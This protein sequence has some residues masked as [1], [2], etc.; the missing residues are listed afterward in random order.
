ML[1][2][3]CIVLALLPLGVAAEPLS[4]NRQAVEI[5]RQFVEI[6]T[7]HSTGSTTE[8]AATA[9]RLLL[10]AGFAE[11]DVQIL[12]EV[13][14]K[15]NLVARYR[16]RTREKKPVLLLA[17]IDVVAA[18]AADWSVPPFQFQEIDGYYYGRGTL[19]DKDEAAAHVANFIRWRREGFVPE[20][21]IV[22]ALTADEEGGPDNGAAYLLREHPDLVDAEFVINEGGGGALVQGRPLYVAIQASEKIYQSYVLEA[23]N[24]G[25]HSSSPRRDNAIYE[26]AEAL[27][28][29]RDYHFPVKLNNVTRA[30]FE[31]AAVIQPDPEIA[32]AMRGV[33]GVP[34]LPEAIAVLERQPVYNAMLRTTCVATLLDAGHAENA[35]PQRAT[36]TVNCRVLPGES[37]DALQAQLVQVVNN[38]SL[39]LRRL[40]EPKPSAPSPLNSVILGPVEKITAELFPGA[41]VLPTMSAGAT[42]SLYF[43]NAGISAYGVSGMLNELGDSR[44]HGRDERIGVDDFAK[45]VEFLYRLVQTLST[46]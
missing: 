17:H 20:R 29:L 23:T 10:E 15:G 26:L 35:L 30:Y 22:L 28:A 43:R 11:D 16:G 36:A 37:I 34:P 42:D 7:T 44:I 39:Q 40:R 3:L 12:E 41:I 4:P 18:D 25:G 6:D 19:D 5:L 31:R 8:L 45:G 21:D 1:F 32:E 9:R 38:K 2:R 24:R 27:L 14:R 46:R 33:L 13:P